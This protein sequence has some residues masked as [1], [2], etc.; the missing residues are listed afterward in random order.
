MLAV[1]ISSFADLHADVLWVW[2]LHCGIEILHC[3]ST[4]E[5]K[6]RA[7]QSEYFA[8]SCVL[9]DEW[10]IWCV[11]YV[12]TGHKLGIF[13]TKLTKQTMHNCSPYDISIEK[14]FSHNYRGIV[15]LAPWYLCINTMAPWIY[16]LWLLCVTPPAKHSHAKHPRVW[17]LCVHPILYTCGTT[18][19]VM[20][21]VL[22]LL[23]CLKTCHA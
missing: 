1:Q 7:Y 3:G 11:Y 10:I 6:S 19:M 14:K 4:K 16:Q 23:C 20:L 9:T 21:W 2:V 8:L 18:A 22:A 5:V 13:L 15:Y 17:C 12:L